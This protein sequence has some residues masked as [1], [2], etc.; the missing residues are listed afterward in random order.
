MS[1]GNGALPEGWERVALGELA[2]IQLGKMLDRGKAPNGPA[3]PYLRNINVR[4]RDFDLDEMFE[5][6]FSEVEAEKFDLRNGDVIVCEGGEP[7]RAAVWNRGPTDI[8]YQKALH[9]VR[10]VEDIEPS[11]LVYRLEHDAFTEALAEHFTG[12]TIK[13]F[14]RKA[15]GAYD[16]PLPPLAEQGRIVSKIESLQE[17]SSRARVA[18]SEV[19]PL[20]DQFRQSVLRAAFSGRLTADWRAAH[21]DVEP[22]TELLNRIRTERRHRWEQSELAKYEAKGKKPPKNWQNKYKEPEPVDDSDFEQLPDGWCWLSVEEVSLPDRPISYGILKP[23]PYE[24][25]GIAML[26]I[27]DMRDGSVDDSKVHRVSQE[28]SDRYGRTLLQGGEVVVS[29]VGTIG[30]VAFVPHALKGANVH[31]NLAVIPT[32][33]ILDGD[34]LHLWLK[35]PI[36]QRQIREFT[37]GGNQPLFNLGDLKQV[38]VPVPP[39]EEQAGIV[40][41]AHDSLE[42]VGV[43]RAELA[44]SESSLT[45]LDQSILAKAFRGE[46]VPQDPRDEPA[47]ELLARIRTT[48][49]AQVNSKPK[50]KRRKTATAR[51]KT[52]ASG[53]ESSDPKITGIIIGL[54]TEYDRLTHDDLIL[55]LAEALELDYHDATESLNNHITHAV[56][57]GIIQCDADRIYSA[58]KGKL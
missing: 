24:E 22:A 51:R 14:T 20:L 49:T 13:H 53:P 48:R 18:L 36:A 40:R 21:R 57:S 52:S 16:L 44:E 37:T 10:L 35:G 31:R 50:R 6:P 47:S 15:I 41:A 17:R 25:N 55:E 12:T 28:L 34:F 5:M 33:P 3:R 4:W 7:G 43:I 2:H 46:L 45:Q 32:M 23:G 38:A 27:T 11:W 8:K 56:E 19:G 26:R 29:L 58:V 54:F 9:R 1:D 42:A 30:A 39:I